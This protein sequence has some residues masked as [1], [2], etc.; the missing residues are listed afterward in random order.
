[1]RKTVVL[2]ALLLIFVSGAVFAKRGLSQ[3]FSLDIDAHS[4]KQVGEKVWKQVEKFFLKAEQ[5]IETENLDD[6]MALYSDNYKNGEHRKYASGQ[7]WKRLFSEF[8]LLATHHDMRF[9]TTTPNSEVMIIRCSGMLVGIPKGA[10]NLIII[11]S[12]TDTDHVLSKAAGDWQLVGSSG[13][14]RKRFWFD[15][16]MHPLF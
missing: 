10:K 7:I 8:D 4:R 16:P 12:W 9:V 1:M 14:E 6:L 15:M 3:Y 5:A 13:H 2:M 11:D